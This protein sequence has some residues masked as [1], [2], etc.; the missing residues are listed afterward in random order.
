MHG[1]TDDLDFSHLIGGEVVSVKVVPYNLGFGFNPKNTINIVG[2]WRIDDA[3][4]AVIDAG[5]AQQH[6]DTLRAHRLLGKKIVSCKPRDRETLVVTF[7]DGWMLS[8]F[9]DDPRYECCAIS[10]GFYI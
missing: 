7:D 9:D 6:N 5:D 10:P 4:G 8:I 1:F 2:R 3:S